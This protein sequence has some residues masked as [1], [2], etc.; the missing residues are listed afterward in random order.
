MTIDTGVGVDI[1]EVEGIDELD[2]VESLFS[3]IWS[4]GPE[5]PPLN[6]EVLRAFAHAGCYVA[7][8]YEGGAMV[9]ASAGF[10]GGG[11]ADEL[12]L[13]SHI[14]GVL[15]AAQ[16]RHVGM[17][18]KLHQRAW[19]LERGIEVVTWTF[20]PLVRRNAWFNLHRLGADVVELVPDF[21]GAMTDGIN[22]GSAS[23]RFVARWSL[24]AATSRAAIVPGDG[25]VLVPVEPS[26]RQALRDAYTSGLH[27]VG[28]TAGG[29]EYVLRP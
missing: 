15:P 27:V 20:D 13:H 9:A 18:L 25:D 23:D 16:G 7:A 8:A 26:S 5:R 24:P 19:C 1:R 4:T 11:G 14:T 29:A 6:R 22:V 12:H 17:A 2:A 28:M 10:L 21:Y 3:T